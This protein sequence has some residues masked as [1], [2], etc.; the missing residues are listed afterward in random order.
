[1]ATANH[2]RSFLG[3]G[4]SFPPTFG[5]G[6]VEVAVAAD[7]DKVQ[8]SLLILLATRP[9]ERPLTDAFGCDLDAHLFEEPDHNAV[10]LIGAKI[11]D[12][13]LRHEPRV[14]LHDVDVDPDPG[15]PSVLRVRLTYGIPGTNSRYNLVF[16]F[17]LNEALAPLA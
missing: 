14:I 5:P 4:W 16:P 13:V 8:Q 3:S 15:D 6:G 1:M 12:A 2:P 7:V 10:G 11:R 9:G 17:Y